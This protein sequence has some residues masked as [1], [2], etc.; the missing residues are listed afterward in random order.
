MPGAVAFAASL[1]PALADDWPVPFELSNV[2]HFLAVWLA[3]EDKIRVSGY[4][5]IIVES[6]ELSEEF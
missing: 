5:P 3:A 4:T 1:L 6:L 2:Q